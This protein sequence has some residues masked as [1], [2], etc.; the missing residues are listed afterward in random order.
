MAKL[1]PFG[2]NLSYVS[3]SAACLLFRSSDLV[4]YKQLES[5]FPHLIHSTIKIFSLVLTR[6]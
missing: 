1:R 4:T 5:P 2:A 3:Y 6:V